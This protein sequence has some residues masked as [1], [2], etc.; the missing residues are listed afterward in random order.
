MKIGIEIECL[1][2][3]DFHSQVSLLEYW[4]TQNFERIDK[5]EVDQAIDAEGI[6][7]F[8]SE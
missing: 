4:A 1:D 2:S 7:I 8:R 5:L 6:S 3:L